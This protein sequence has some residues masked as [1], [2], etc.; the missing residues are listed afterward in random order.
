MSDILK[1]RFC[2]LVCAKEIFSHSLSPSSLRI[3]A[4]SIFCHWTTKF[5]S[6][7]LQLLCC[8][9]GHDKASSDETKHE[10]VDQRRRFSS[11]QQ[12]DALQSLASV[13]QSLLFL[14][15]LLPFFIFFFGQF[16]LILAEWKCRFCCVQSV[17]SCTCLSNHHLRSI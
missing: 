5:H 10:R 11:T 14:F 4:G 16:I 17:T 13:E 8:A 7:N 3:S 2:G 15:S 12:E 9:F 1:N 6:A